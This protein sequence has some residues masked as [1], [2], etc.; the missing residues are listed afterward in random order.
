MGVFES[1]HGTEALCFT[2]F[3]LLS[4]TSIP[5]APRV[6]TIMYAQQL[7][8]SQCT[9]LLNWTH[10]CTCMSPK[11][12]PVIQGCHFKGLRSPC[13]CA[14]A[15]KHTMEQAMMSLEGSGA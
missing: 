3:L 12:E 13:T 7:G 5:S 8:K 9:M 4:S 15:C 11:V 6:L 10:C 2:C 14:A 1:A